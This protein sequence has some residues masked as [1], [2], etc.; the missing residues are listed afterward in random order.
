MKL[1]GFEKEHV[2]EAIRI[3][4]PAV[5]ESFFIALV[6]MID[7]YM[8]SELGAESVAAVG[9]TTQPKMVA[10]SIFFAGNVSISALVARRKG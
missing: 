5:L 2:K 3:A 10:L 1:F 4:W 9:L 7:S 8:V 6:A